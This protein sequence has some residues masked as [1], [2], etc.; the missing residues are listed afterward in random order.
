MPRRRNPKKKT[1]PEIAYPTV[2][3]RVTKDEG[4]S[5]GELITGFMRGLN[6]IAAKFPFELYEVM[7]NLVM[8]DPYVSKYH[9]TTLSLGNTGHK[10][11]INAPN[12]A[13]AKEAIQCAND[14]AARCLPFGGGMDGLIGGLFSQTARAGGCCAEWVPDPSLSRIERAYL[15][16]I[17]SLRFRYRADESLE[18]CQ[19]QADGLVPLNPVQ[20]VYHAAVIKDGNPYST[21]P[22]IAVLESCA[23]HRVIN[24]KIR[25][26]MDKI[27]ALGVLLAEVEPPPRNPGEPQEDYDARA[28]TYL[29]RIATSIQENMSS[30]L[31]VGYNNIKFTFQNTQASAQG[32]KDILQIVLQGLFSSL[33]RDPVLFGWNFNTTESFAKVVYEEMVQGIKSFQLGVKRAVEHG[34][35]LNFALSGFGDCSVSVSFNANRSID[36]FRDAEAEYMKTQS[37]LA[38]L[39]ANILT[40]EEVRKEL[41]Y[42]DQQAGAG[43]FVASFNR[44]DRRYS[45]NPPQTQVWHIGWDNK[46][47]SDP[48]VTE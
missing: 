8:H 21:P 12:E 13:R 3:A 25:T 22:A 35:R 37:M 10:L 41:G 48:A 6:I 46:L 18:L 30:G 16:P 26:W 44:I 36:E 15:V 7:D 5:Y 32:A 39:E 45:L 4:Q 33:Q 19:E 17:K 42:N 9:F 47:K 28:A 31:G 38:K 23:T 29:Q 14:L 43:E 1:E 40:P 2:T 20:T 27:S 11:N 24:Q 34:H